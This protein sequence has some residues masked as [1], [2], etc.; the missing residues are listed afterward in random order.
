M[1][2]IFGDT[3]MEK[4]NDLEFINGQIVYNYTGL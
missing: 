2:K 1:E 3:G 4:E